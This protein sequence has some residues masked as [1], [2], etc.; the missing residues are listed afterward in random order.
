MRSYT[1]GVR[2]E[3]RTISREQRQMPGTA[4]HVHVEKLGGETLAYVNAAHEKE[5]RVSKAKALH[6]DAIMSWHEPPV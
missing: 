3:H 5:I 6:M 1:M 2:P 4:S